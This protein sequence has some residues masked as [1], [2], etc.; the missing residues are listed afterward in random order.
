MK[1]RKRSKQAYMFKYNVDTA[2][3]YAYHFRVQILLHIWTVY[4]FTFSEPLYAHA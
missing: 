3:K 1:C 4:I 2:R